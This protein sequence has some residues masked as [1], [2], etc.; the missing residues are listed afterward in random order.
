MYEYNIVLQVVVLTLLYSFAGLGIAIVNDFK[1]I[2]G[3]RAMGLR[4]LP[5]E[6]GIE[7]AKWICVG[8]I[9]I[10]QLSIA[11]YL[12]GIDEK[13]YSFVLLCL[14]APQVC[15]YVYLRVKSGI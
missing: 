12:Y 8:M 9:D 10:T 3:D 13:W 11:A 5:V 6:F 15:K 14:I 7:K 1:S 4:S 2:E